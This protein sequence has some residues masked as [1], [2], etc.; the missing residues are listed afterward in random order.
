MAQMI[1]DAHEQYDIEGFTKLGHIVHRELVQFE[2]NA[3]DRGRKARLR[4]IQGFA[5]N[6]HHA[7][8][9][10]PFHLQS[11]ESAIASNIEDSLT[12]QIGWE[13]IGKALPFHARIIA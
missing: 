4:Q 3:A 8:S 10:T 9:A 7:R 12:V 11:V 6:A 1:E 2:R 5:I 13:G